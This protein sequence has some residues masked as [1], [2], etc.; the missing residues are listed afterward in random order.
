MSKKGWIALLLLICTFLSGFSIQQA[1]AVSAVENVNNQGEAAREAESGNPIISP[2]AASPVLTI[3][4][5]QVEKGNNLTLNWTTSASYYTYEVWIGTSSRKSDVFKRD[6]G[7]RSSYSFNTFDLSPGTYYA[8]IVGFHDDGSKNSNS[9]PFTVISSSDTQPPTAPVASTTSITEKSVAIKWTASRDNVG[10]KEYRVFKNGQQEGGGLSTSTTTYTFHLLNSGTPYTF[11]VMAVD[12]A[13]NTSKSNVLSVQTPGPDTR[14][15][16]APVIT[17]VSKTH[18][19]ITLS[20]P[21]TDNV[22]VVNYQIRGSV[23][24]R[25]FYD[26]YTTESTH[27]IRDLLPNQYYLFR[28]TAF[29]AAGNSTVSAWHTVKTDPQPADTQPPT[30]PVLSSTSKTAQS[31]TLSWTA[32][33]DNVGVT[34]YDVY[35]N[36]AYHATTTNRTMVISRL[37]PYTSYRFMVRAKDAAGNT[38]SSNTLTVTTSEL[39][40]SLS[41]G[42]STLMEAEANDGSFSA[43]QIV[44]L[45]GSTFTNSLSGNVSVT[46]LPPGLTISVTRKSNTQIAISFLGKAVNHASQNDVTNA[47]IRILPAAINGVGTTKTSGTFAFRFRDPVPVTGT[48][49]YEYDNLNRLVRIKQ[50]ST[51]IYEFTYDKNG[52]VKSKVKR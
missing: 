30:A 40:V 23:N 15:P 4:P 13:G 22:G 48:Y 14:P 35:V 39:A 17:T 3:T 27:T 43:Q 37:T 31:V 52:N 26:H 9:Q 2:M 41:L 12:R 36:G 28:V 50:G 49:T 7:F 38:A 10:L 18:N 29:D 21:A 24:D 25:Y 45:S 20:Y 46:N 16:S 47:T 33:T 6:V 11:Y 51:V 5:T 34:G 42:S 19:S 8:M 32:S 1:N 44:T